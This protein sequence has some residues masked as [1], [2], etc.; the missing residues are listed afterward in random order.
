MK[1]PW[2]QRK[3]NYIAQI[4]HK[5]PDELRVFQARR[6]GDVRRRAA[7]LARVGARRGALRTLRRD[8]PSRGTEHA[9]TEPEITPEITPAPEPPAPGIA[10]GMPC[11]MFTPRPT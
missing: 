10:P 9:M 7:A 2:R 4:P 1:A 11:G 3:E 5:A 8:D 6:A